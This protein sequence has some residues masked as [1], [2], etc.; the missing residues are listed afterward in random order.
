MGGRHYRPP[1]R[2]RRLSS[3]LKPASGQ[4][5]LEIAARALAQRRLPGPLSYSKS[6]SGRFERA[7]FSCHRQINRLCC[8]AISVTI[9]RSRPLSLSRYIPSFALLAV[10][11]QAV[12]AAPSDSVTTSPGLRW[13]KGN[14]HTHTTLSD[15]DS[16]PSVVARWYRDN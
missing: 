8:R 16:S 4:S 13:F 1:R 3:R 7:S 14:T 2:P 15:G 11:V 6:P 10:L 12:A 9:R 5:V